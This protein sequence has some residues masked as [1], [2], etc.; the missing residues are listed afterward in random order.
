MSGGLAFHFVLT[1]QIAIGSSE[2]TPRPKQALRHG[3]T[4]SQ[5]STMTAFIVSSHCVIL[6]TINPGM[7]APLPFLGVVTNTSSIMTDIQFSLRWRTENEVLDGTGETTCANMRCEYH[8]PHSALTPPSL[9]T[10][11]L[12]FAYEEQGVTKQALVKVVL[13]P[14]C[15]GKLMWKRTRERRME[16][17]KVVAEDGNESRGRESDGG[18]DSKNDKRRTQS[19]SRSAS[20]R[21]RKKHR[22]RREASHERTSGSGKHDVAQKS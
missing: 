21:P 18:L 4:N 19:R 22:G 2:L 10:L 16:K 14:K 12:P 5:R 20:P 1:R 7:Y 15:V 13:C 11:E 3:T 9:T 8:R 17:G 6:N